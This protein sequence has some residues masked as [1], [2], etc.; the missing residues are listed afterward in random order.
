MI[1]NEIAALPAVQEGGD[2]NGSKAYKDA[3][4]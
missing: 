2:L 1:G 4:S 3:V